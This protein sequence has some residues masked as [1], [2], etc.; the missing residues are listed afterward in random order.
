MKT[1]SPERSSGP[2][3]STLIVSSMEGLTVARALESHLE[4]YVQATMWQDGP[5]GLSS[6]NLES[7]VQAAAILSGL[8]G[9]IFCSKWVSLWVRWAVAGRSSC[10]ARKIVSSSPPIWQAL[11]GP[12]TSADPMT[13]GDRHSV[14]QPQSYGKQCKRPLPDRAPPS[15]Y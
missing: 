15:L 14:Q 5:F 11:R 7:L 3:H 10:A 2:S 9:T 8:R 13:T 6:A 1:T 12:L 4:G